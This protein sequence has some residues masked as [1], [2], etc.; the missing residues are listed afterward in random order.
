MLTQTL[1]CSIAIEARIIGIAH[2]AHK[3]CKASAQKDA[4][5]P[6]SLASDYGNTIRKVHLLVAFNNARDINAKDLIDLV[7]LAKHSGD[8][9]VVCATIDES[10]N[11]QFI[12]Y[13]CLDNVS[14]IVDVPNCSRIYPDCDLIK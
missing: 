8:F 14:E 7:L 2:G 13:N 12:G 9:Y 4:F 3:I 11:L 10:D 1:N 5:W 6:S